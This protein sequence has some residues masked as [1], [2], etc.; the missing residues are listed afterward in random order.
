MLLMHRLCLRLTWMNQATS[1]SYATG[2]AMIQCDMSTCCPFFISRTAGNPTRYEC[3][4]INYGSDKSLDTEKL[5]DTFEAQ[6]IVAPGEIVALSGEYTLD[7]K[8]HYHSVVIHTDKGFCDESSTQSVTYGSN[9]W[10]EAG[11]ESTE[12]QPCHF[13]PDNSSVTRECV[14]KGEWSNPDYSNCYTM[15]TSMYQDFD[16]VCN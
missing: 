13:G 1:N 16:V 12:Q 14:F 5:R 2:C 8:H 7:V 11:V 9:T 3:Q 15:I 4:F 6:G 10:P